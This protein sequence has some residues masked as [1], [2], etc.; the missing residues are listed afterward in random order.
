MSDD[1]LSFRVPYGVIRTFFLVSCFLSGIVL[2]AALFRDQ[3]KPAP[4]PPPPAHVCPLPDTSASRPVPAFDVICPYCRRR[5]K[6][7]PT[8]NPLGAKPTAQAKGKAQ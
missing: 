4:V 8:P 7:D 5:F 1:D 3:P 2:H 6:V